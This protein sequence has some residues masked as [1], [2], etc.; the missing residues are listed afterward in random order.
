MDLIGLSKKN[1]EKI[2]EYKKE[3]ADI[4]KFRLDSYKLFNEK[5]EPNFGPKHNID[6][7][8][9]IFYKPLY[10]TYIENSWQRIDAKVRD[11]LDSVGVLDTEKYMGGMGVQYES[12][13]IY[14]NMIDELKKKN[15]IF[16]SIEDGMKNYPELVFKYFGTIVKNNDNKYAALNGAV[17]SGGS[18]IYVPPHTKLDRPLQSYFR[19]SSENMGQFERTLIVVDEGSDVHYIEGCTAPEYPTSALHAAV[20]EI[21]VAKNARCRYTTVQNWAENVCNLVT[22]RALVQENGEMEWIDGN[23][24]GSINMKYP[25]CILMGDNSKGTCISIGV[26]KHNQIQDTGA[27]MIHIGKNTKSNIV[28]KSIASLGGE[29]NYRGIVDIKPSATNS[30]AMVKCDTLILDEGSKSDAFPVNIIGNRSSTM[31][32]EATVSKVNKEALFYLQARGINEDK[33]VELIVLGFLE[34]FREELPMEYAVE[35][36]QILKGETYHFTNG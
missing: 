2:S 31:E 28:A 21:Y 14:H 24:G 27:K 7:S 19:I 34:R 8:K 20:V 32:H 25:S 4:L 29:A 18:F 9:I 22:K 15:I 11:E 17:F 26:A 33:A 5:K 23:I 13:V 30:Y 35:L 3:S 6:F 16:T 1:I 12:E 10:E 36:N